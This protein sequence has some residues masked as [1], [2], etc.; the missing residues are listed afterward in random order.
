MILHVRVP[1]LS[2]NR[3]FTWKKKKFNFNLQSNKTEI[4]GKQMKFKENSGRDLGPRNITMQ[5]YYSL[6]C[7]IKAKGKQSGKLFNGIMS[8]LSV[9]AARI[10]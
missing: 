6:V 4:N 1:V 10:K 3:Y 5:V 2:E 9:N 7:H 8:Y